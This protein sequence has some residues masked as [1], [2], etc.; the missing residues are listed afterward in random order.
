LGR[1]QLSEGTRRS[2]ARRLQLFIS[3]ERSD[4]EWARSL[5]D[6]LEKYND[7]SSPY[8]FCPMLD[9]KFLLAGDDWD[10][11]IEQTV[12]KSDYFL[13]LNSNNLASKAIGYVNKEIKLALHRQEYMASGIKFII[14]LGIDNIKP[15]VG[16]P[17]LLPFNQ[18]PLRRESFE[19]DVA[20]IALAIRRDQQVRGRQRSLRN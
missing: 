4:E 6:A 10:P 14:P 5:R 11:S 16:P 1:Y 15:E 19:D 7:D 20:Q 17:E 3:Y 8:S 13:V 2:K 12:L 18:V 9:R